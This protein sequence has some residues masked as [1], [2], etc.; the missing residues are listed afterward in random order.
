VISRPFTRDENLS[1]NGI[2]S[3]VTEAFS[4]LSTAP[5]F[6]LPS[7]GVPNTNHPLGSVDANSSNFIF[8]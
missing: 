6:S 1:L 8:V 7:L 3:P 2:I 5:N 4:S